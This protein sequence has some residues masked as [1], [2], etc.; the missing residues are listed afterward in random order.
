MDTKNKPFRKEVVRR[1]KVPAARLQ[2][3]LLDAGFFAALETEEGLV[4]FCVT[5]K[6]GKEEIDALVNSLKEAEL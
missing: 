5:E 1:S 4:S 2:Q 3:V 6:H